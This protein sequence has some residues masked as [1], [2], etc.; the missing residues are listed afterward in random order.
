MNEKETL[1]AEERKDKILQLLKDSEKVTVAQLCDLFGISPVTARNDLRDLENENQLRRTHGGAIRMS[2][3][4]YELEPSKRDENT[5]QKRA[6]AAVAAEM[7]TDGDTIIIDTGSTCMEFAKLLAGKRNLRVVTND[8]KIALL[9]DPCEDIT[10]YFIG[11]VLRKH[12]NCT[13]GS[14]G[15]EPFRR[16]VV[17]KAFM[18]ANSLSLS[19]GAM[20][21]DV[22]Q[23]EIKK[24]MLSVADKV[25]IL[26]GSNKIGQNSFVTFAELSEIDTLVTDSGL[27]RKLR[28]SLEE[29]GIDVKIA[30]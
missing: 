27:G 19:R 17:D 28:E 6:I 2:S 13:V 22:G 4:A 15:S 25:I 7:V 18:G 10:L 30:P 23:A 12:Y 29:H 11:G 1:F 20:T 9:L 5:D 26:C 14:F 24:T 16:L 8:L 3:S 21:P